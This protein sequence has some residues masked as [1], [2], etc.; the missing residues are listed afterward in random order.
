[1]MLADC[2]CQRLS[3]RVEPAMALKKVQEKLKKQGLALKIFDAYRPFSVTCKIWKTVADRRY[4]SNPKNGSNHNRGVAVDLTL[5]DLN[6]GREL[7]MGT[8]FDNFTDTAHHDF[9]N[10]PSNVLANRK[11]LKN[12]MRKFGFNIVPSEWWHY[13]WARRSNYEVVNLSF[14][15]IRQVMKLARQ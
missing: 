8:V 12:V 9:C 1:M 15:E 5:I 11:V 13:Q 4:V 7:D 14:D 10:L 2:S 6:T 3:M